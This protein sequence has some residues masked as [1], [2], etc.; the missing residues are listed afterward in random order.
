MLFKIE[1]TLNPL[2][3]SGGRE[4]HVERVRAPAGG[5]PPHCHHLPLVKGNLAASDRPISV[6][7][8]PRWHRRAAPHATRTSSAYSP[9]A[10]L[11]SLWE[12]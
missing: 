10:T 7:E 8:P 4:R 5:N 6:W 2:V 9:I 3:P 11:P 12:A 1:S